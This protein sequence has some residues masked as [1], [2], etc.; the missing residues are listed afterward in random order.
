MSELKA[1]ESA[2]LQL[3]SRASLGKRERRTLQRGEGHTHQLERRPFLL[4]RWCVYDACIYSMY[5]NGKRGL[6]K[7]TEELGRTPG[8]WGKRYPEKQTGEGASFPA[9][10]EARLRVFLAYYL[11]AGPEMYPGCSSVLDR[12]HVMR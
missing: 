9:P 1:K 12:V 7:P 5:A 6:N 2:L 11:G 10:K 3:L 8:L 4:A